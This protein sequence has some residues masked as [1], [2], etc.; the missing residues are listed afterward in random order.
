MS[1]EQPGSENSL[2]SQSIQEVIWGGFNEGAT[3]AAFLYSY[4]IKMQ[5]MWDGSLS[6]NLEALSIKLMTTINSDTLLIRQLLKVEAL[7]E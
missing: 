1:S 6:T 5:K 4:L 3:V 7:R 2:P